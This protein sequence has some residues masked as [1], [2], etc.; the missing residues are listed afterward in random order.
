MVRE[1]IIKE[2][3]CEWPGCGASY[4]EKKSA[5]KCEAKGLIGPELKPG[6]VLGAGEVYKS[7]WISRDKRTVEGSPLINFFVLKGELEPEG[8]NKVYGFLNARYGHSHGVFSFED[9]TKYGRNHKWYFQDEKFSTG[10]LEDDLSFSWDRNSNIRELAEGELV[11]VLNF[12]KEN[13]DGLELKKKLEKRGIGKLRANSPYIK[14]VLKGKW[15][16]YHS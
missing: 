4:D 8:H 7:T 12:I 2:Y 11:S 14:R 3:E 10:E 1:K 13:P 9:G 15:D 16:E 5:V 6:L